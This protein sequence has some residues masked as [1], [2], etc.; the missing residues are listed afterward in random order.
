[1]LLF[2]QLGLSKEHSSW[3]KAVFGGTLLSMMAACSDT[4]FDESAYILIRE[5]SLLPGQVGVRAYFS[6]E[7]ASL[8]GGSCREVVQLANEAVESRKSRGETHVVKYECVSLAEAKARGV[9]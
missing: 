6:G 2:P 4:R 1:M 3:L 5:N 7:G 9:K 8:N